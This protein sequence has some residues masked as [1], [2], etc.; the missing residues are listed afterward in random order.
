MLDILTTLFVSSTCVIIIIQTFL[1]NQDTS[2]LVYFLRMLNNAITDSITDDTIVSS[3][4]LYPSE[5]HSI[6]TKCLSSILGYMDKIAC[7]FRK[8]VLVIQQMR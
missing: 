6:P 3:F 4:N 2:E 1:S 8:L 5:T 7:A